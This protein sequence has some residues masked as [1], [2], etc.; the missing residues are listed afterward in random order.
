MCFMLARIRLRTLAYRRRGK[1]R[2]S[3]QTVDDNDRNENDIILPYREVLIFCCF[4][5]YFTHIVAYQIT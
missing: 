2:H 5:F 3:R 1:E 4:L